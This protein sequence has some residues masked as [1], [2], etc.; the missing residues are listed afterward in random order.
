LVKDL[1]KLGRDLKSTVIIDNS[2]NSYK[3]QPK[4]AIPI[5]TWFDDPN[6]TELY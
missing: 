4:N 1:S 2:S 5:S 6:D 3:F